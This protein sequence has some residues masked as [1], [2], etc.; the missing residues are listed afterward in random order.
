V[1]ENWYR[2]IPESV[3][4]EKSKLAIEFAITKDGKVAD[5]RLVAS[6]GDVALDRPAWMSVTVE[7]ISATKQDSVKLKRHCPNHCTA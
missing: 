3:E 4:M 1:K 6:S 7:S 5:I 2:L